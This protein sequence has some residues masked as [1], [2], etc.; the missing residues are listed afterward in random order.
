MRILIKIFFLL[1]PFFLLSCARKIQDSSN[2]VDISEEL[3]QIKKKASTQINGDDLIKLP[4]QEK[5]ISDIPIGNKDPFSQSNSIS[6][7][8]SSENLKLVGILSVK[9]NIMAFIS[10]KNESGLVRIGD[11][12]GKDTNLL[13]NGYKTISINQSKGSMTIK[14]KKDTYVLKI[15][16]KPKYL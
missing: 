4:T 7:L 3:A 10:Y 9:N 13:P 5:V 1:T 15:F 12:G 8:I 11:I 2:V 14:L 6:R 16:N